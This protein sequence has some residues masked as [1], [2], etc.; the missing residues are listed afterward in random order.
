MKKFYYLDDRK[1]SRT[2]SK[3]N[4]H[5]LFDGNNFD[6]EKWLTVAIT[7]QIARF[8]FVFD[9]QNFAGSADF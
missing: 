7:T 4:I 6:L 2:F 3:I 8:L 1:Y 9:Y 5:R